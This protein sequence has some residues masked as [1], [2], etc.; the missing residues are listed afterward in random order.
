MISMN[1]W[2]AQACNKLMEGEKIVTGRKE[3]I[4]APAVAAQ[5]KSFCKQDPEFAKAVCQG[6]TFKDC[7]KKVAADVGDSISDLNAYKMAVQ[8]YFPGAEVGMKLTLDLIGK[9]AEGHEAEVEKTAPALRIHKE[10]EMPS[11]SLADFFG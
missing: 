11:L 6:G 9:A 7:M 2:T 1:T 10:Y 3:K 5:L 4:M 8:F